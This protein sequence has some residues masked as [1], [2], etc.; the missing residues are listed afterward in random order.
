[1]VEEPLARDLEKSEALVK[2]LDS[3]GLPVRAALWLYQSDAERWRFV[4]A[5]REKRKD[6]TTFYR[7]LAEAVNS[8]KNSEDLLDLSKV[9]VVDPESPLV[10]NLSKVLRMDGMGRARFTNNRING[11]L[12]EDALIFRMAA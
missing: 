12:L 3:N 11:I 10:A 6:Y 4:L 7:D 2:H 9:D 8:S 1:M 5:F